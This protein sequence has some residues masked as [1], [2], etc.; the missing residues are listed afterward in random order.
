MDQALVMTE[1]MLDFAKKGQWDEIINL[2]AGRQKIIMANVSTQ[3]KVDR[4]TQLGEIIQKIL[5]LDGEIQALVLKERN[6]VKDD[7]IEFNQA[8]SKAKA[9]QQTP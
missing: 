5:K 8:K 2:E 1:Q 4:Q 3:R 9:Y 6:A 7:L